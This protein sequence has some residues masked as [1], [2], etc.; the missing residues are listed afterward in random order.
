M[1]S[2]RPIPNSAVANLLNAAALTIIV[3]ILPVG[4]FAA[5]S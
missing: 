2:E 3:L 4:F 1:G 5:L